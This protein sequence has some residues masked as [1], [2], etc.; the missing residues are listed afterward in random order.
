MG[1]MIYTNVLSG[2]QEIENQRVQR[3][4]RRV[5]AIIESQSSNLNN[6]LSD[7]TIW[8]DT[9]QFLQ[10]NNSEYI[11]SNIS[12]ESFISSGV[13]EALFINKK[14]DILIDFKVNRP[15]NE[16]S[17]VSDDLKSH[18]S[19]GSALLRLSKKDDFKK[20]ILKIRNTLVLFAVRPVV[21]SDG[22]GEA[23]GWV[24]FAEYFDKKMI[25][26]MQELTQFAADMTLWEDPHIPSDFKA[27]KSEYINNNTLIRN[28][29]IV[30]EKIISGFFIVKDYY[31]NPQ[32]IVRSDI[33]RDINTQGRMSMGKLMTVLI[34]LGL[35]LSF[36]QFVLMNEGV[37]KKIFTISQELKDI[38]NSKLQKTRLL[39]ENSRDEIDM[40]RINI[41]TMLADIEA[42]QSQLKA[43]VEKRESLVELINSIVVML[44]SS[45][46]ISMINKKGCEI[47][48]YSQEELI[49]KDWIST[50]LIPEEQEMIRKKFL[51][52]INSDR[53]EN[54]YIENSIL[55]KDKKIIIYGWHT[56]IVKN[57][58]GKAISTLSVGNDITQ[59]KKEERIKE[60]YT[61]NLKRMNDVMI[62]RELKMIELKKRIVELEKNT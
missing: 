33:G 48:G 13:D 51:E 11:K 22:T 3:N 21:K 57:V 36:L 34:G 47:L 2:F 59:I 39:V 7:W 62:G 56:S 52:L 37:L 55:T 46:N 16:K 1:F 5:A 53:M 4:N 17:D 15:L 9:Y 18:F 6:N 30:N 44:D 31:G 10:D 38:G 29:K 8:D 20:G 28:S 40:L 50:V 32:A 12:Q 43:E 54:C 60:D 58:Q 27:I 26:S 61:D 23:A 19:T 41:N 25:N 24:V 14:S 35:V 45:G 42:S 49:G